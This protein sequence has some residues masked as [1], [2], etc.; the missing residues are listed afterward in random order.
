MYVLYTH[1]ISRCACGIAY[2]PAPNCVCFNLAVGMYIYLLPSPLEVGVLISLSKLQFSYKSGAELRVLRLKWL[3]DQFIRRT[4]LLS[5]NKGLSCILTPPMLLY[6]RISILWTP[7]MP[8]PMLLYIRIAGLFRGRKFPQV[9]GLG[10]FVENIF[11]DCNIKTIATS[12]K[13]H[14]SWITCARHTALRA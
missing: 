1:H 3:G 2:I 7:A 11:A 4:T 10:H 6:I 8:I 13:E 9:V 14:V 12:P 5:K